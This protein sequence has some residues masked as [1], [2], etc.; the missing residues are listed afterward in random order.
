EGL[1]LCAATGLTGCGGTR[2]HL[3]Q[4]GR[5]FGSG[6][7]V[8]MTDGHTGSRFQ[9]VTVGTHDL[10]GV[11]TVGQEVQYRDEKKADRAV[12]V[13]QPPGVGMVEHEKSAFRMGVRVSN[14]SSFFLGASTSCVWHD[15]QP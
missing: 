12:E 15:G 13:D 8:D 7:V 4:Q 3:L 1:D 5:T 10:V 9:G 14:R 2:V 11:G 6:F